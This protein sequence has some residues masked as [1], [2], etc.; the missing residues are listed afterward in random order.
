MFHRLNQSVLPLLFL[1]LVSCSSSED[2]VQPIKKREFALPVQI[3][4][5][6]RMN[7]ADEVR[8]VG[9][10][11]AEKRVVV[12]SEVR[13][14]ITRIAVEEG[15][16]VKA[17]D[18]LAQI[19]PREFELVHERLRA[20]LT[21]MQKEYQKAQGGLRPE[22]KQRLEARMHADESALNLTNIELN[23]TQNLVAQKV[24]SQSALDSAKDKVRQADESLKASK[25][26]LAAGM[27]ARSE[28]IEKLESD[29]QAI[30]KRVAVAKLN[31]SKVNVKAPFAGV[32]IA[33]EIEQG[34]FAEAGTPI[35]RMIG[36]S[37][38]KAV[39]EMPQ[40]HRNKLKKLKGARFMARELG[41]KFEQNKNLQR[42]IRV[43]P[44]ANIFSGNIKVQID[45]PDPNSSLFPGLTLESTLNFGM[46]KNVLHVPAVSL[47]I[48]EKGTVVYVVKDGKAHRVPVKAFKE[49]DDFVEIEDL[50]HQLKPETDLILRG[51]GA[52]FPGVKVF[53]T[54]LE[55][56]SK[57]GKPA[58]AKTS[59]T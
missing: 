45:L 17:G 13:G 36:S 42:L 18:L 31:L 26:E 49:R 20:D 38:L 39:L 54:N 27:K 29:M 55:P 53:I 15:M 40:S 35:V 47:V 6:V 22:D 21:S 4:K 41:L 44:D 34:A 33:K 25:A 8:A 57:D 59:G 56:K 37:R 51:S 3:G 30:R 19:D 2:D 48:S 24:L 50:T 32:I 52:V 5:I 10:V 14:K 1:T 11:Q 16:K 7:V 58:P 23:R 9:N 46:R 12:N 28:D 43:I